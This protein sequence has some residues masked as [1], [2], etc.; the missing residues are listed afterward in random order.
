VPLHGISDQPAGEFVIIFLRNVIYL[1]LEK[2]RTLL[3]LMQLIA[4]AGYLFL[5]SAEQP[6]DGSLWT[7]VLSGS[8]C[9]DRPR[10]LHEESNR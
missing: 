4:P 9:H 8:T 7:T 1:S 6:L 3:S 10:Q 2:R 5:G